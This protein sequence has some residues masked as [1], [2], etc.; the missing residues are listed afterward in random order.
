[1]NQAL[2]SKWLTALRSGNYKQSKMQL[3]SD[4]GYCCLGVLCEVS[5]EG[6]FVEEY[7]ELGDCELN[8]HHR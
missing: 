3:K 7:N 6:E 5:G 1:M 4:D 8:F 2:K